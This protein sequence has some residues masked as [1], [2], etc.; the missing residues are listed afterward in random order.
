M[1]KHSRPINYA[2]K[3]QQPN[4]KFQAHQQSKAKAFDPKSKLSALQQKFKDKLEGGRFRMINGECL[5]LINGDDRHV[6]LQLVS[7]LFVEKLYTSESTDAFREFQR[8]PKL[9]DVYHEGY[10]NQVEGWPINPLDRI[11]QWIR[12]KPKSAIVADMGCGEARLARSLKNKVHSFDLVDNSSNLPNQ[13]RVE[14]VACDIA[15]VPLEDNSVDIVVFCLSLMGTNIVD[16]IK[17]AYRILKPGGTVKIAEV[18]SRFHN[19]EGAPPAPSKG[20]RGS[21]DDDKGINDFV[22]IIVDMGFELNQSGCDIESNKMF[23]FLECVKSAPAG[24]TGPGG[25][26][27]AASAALAPAHGRDSSHSEAQ[28]GGKIKKQ[29]DGST[30]S[31]KPCL[32]KRR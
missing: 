23:F 32:Y 8:D 13:K 11:I 3:A 15:H 30:F 24:S 12:T 6:Y 14:V 9:F 29:T 27:V 17:E 26:V 28:S 20:G 2:P 18:R 1:G 31:A 25:A 22:E 10:R 5:L 21:T 4:K 7:L 19:I 16:F